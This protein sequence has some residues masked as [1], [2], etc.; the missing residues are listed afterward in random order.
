MKNLLLDN[1]VSKFLALDEIDS[2]V[3]SGSCASNY[4]DE[5]SDYDIYIYSQ[6]NPDICIRKNIAESFCSKF[7]IDNRFFETGDEWYI[8]DTGQV[9][10]I[11]YRSN[12]W[13]HNEMDRVWN[14]HN[15]SVG[16]S[17][18]FLYNIKNSLI[19]Y[20]KFDKFKNARDVL[21]SPFPD[22][23]CTNIINKN[24]PLL[25]DKLASSYYSQIEKAILR[26]D[27]I[28]IN[29]RISAFLASYFDVLFAKNKLLHPGEKRLIRFALDKCTILPEDFSENINTLLS[30]NENKLMILDDMVLKLKKIL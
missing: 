19:L 2:I 13:L 15:A 24:F 11:M 16:Y 25:K 10:D 1:I 6:N 20:D 4:C 26:K 21:N 8:S 22:R 30:L 5:Y 9:I 23:L 29:H 28:S 12:E 7:E 14:K 27:I 18:C 3:L 17:T